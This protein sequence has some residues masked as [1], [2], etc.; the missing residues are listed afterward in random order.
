MAR[1]HGQKG[2][3]RM[4]G[5]IVAMKTWELDK[6]TDKVP[7]TSFG[8][9]NKVYVQGLPDVKGTFTGFWDN[10]D[11]TFLT[12]SETA[13]GATL[14]LYPSSLVA[15]AY[16]Y[17]PALVDYKMSVDVNGAV[18]VSGSFVANGSWGHAGL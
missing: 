14:S 18:Q 8:D 10:A 7:V 11:T 5:T 15:G 17:G 4:G 2:V 13:G 16:H 3:V 6:S 9:T 1:Y 12:T